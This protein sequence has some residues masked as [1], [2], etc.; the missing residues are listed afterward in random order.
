MAQVKIYGHARFLEG[1]RQVI[2]DAIHR[3]TVRELG[4]PEDKRY[5]RFFA[6]EDQDF[7]HPDGRS[8]AYLILEIHLFAGRTP[9]TLRAYLLALQAA[10]EDYAGL[11]PND[12]EVTLIEVPAAHWS[13]RGQPG[14]E[15]PLPYEVHQ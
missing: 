3:A 11:A 9:K 7:I 12:L 14:D 8:G 1:R 13:I 15:Q 4:Q 5:H 6:L 2:S 10:L